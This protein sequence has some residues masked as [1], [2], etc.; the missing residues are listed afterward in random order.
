MEYCD[1]SNGDIGDSIEN[2]VNLLETI[3]VSATAAIDLKEQVYAYLHVELNDKIYFD[4]GDFG[5]H[6]FSI[7]QGLAVQLNNLKYSW[8]L[9]IY[10]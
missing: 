5:Y 9:L 3:A 4:Y 2:A 8:T 7:F 1:D 10:K 6:L